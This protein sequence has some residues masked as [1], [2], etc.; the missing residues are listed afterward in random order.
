MIV[1]PSSG[2]WQLTQLR[3]LLPSSRKNG[4]RRSMKPL[5]LIVTATP[6]SLRALSSCGPCGRR[7]SSSSARAA[8]SIV[9][10]IAS[11]RIAFDCHL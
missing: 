1:Q 7:R 6:L 5:L 4:L 11:T 8:G 3:P 10:P 2:W 9:P